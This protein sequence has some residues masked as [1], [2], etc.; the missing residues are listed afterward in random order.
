MKR[1]V[2][3]IVLMLCAF[4]AIGMYG[5][6]PV[7]P[8]IGTWEFAAPMPEAR[9]RATAVALGDYIYVIGGKGVS[10]TASRRVDRYDPDSDSWEE[11]EPLQIGRFDAASVVWNNS[12]VVVG[13]RSEN[14]QT[15]NTVE[16][17]N[18][19]TN[20]WTSLGS[21]IESREGHAAVVLNDVIYTAGGSDAV[22]RIFDTVEMYDPDL[23]SWSVS[24][25]WMLDFPRASFA[26]AAVNDS[27]FTIGGFNTFGPLSLVQ[28][29]HPEA[30]TAGRESISPARGGLAAVQKGDRVFALGGITTNFQA[31]STT[32]VYFPAENRWET[33]ASMNTPRAQF[34]AVIFEN[35]LF[36]FGG[37]DAQGI[38][39]ESVEVFISGVA[40][41]ATDDAFVTNE[42]VPLSFNV[43]ANDSDPSG[44]SITISNLSK[45]PGGTVVQP[46]NGAGTLT[47][48]PNKDFSG[49]DRFTYTIV[50]EEGSVASAE[51]VITVVP[52]NDPPAFV[53]TPIVDGVSG[54]VYAYNVQV[55][56][57][58]GPMV[59]ITTD[60]IPGWLSLTDN[61]DG[62]ALLTGTPTS[63]DVGNHVV[64]LRASDGTAEQVQSFIISVFQ[65]IPPIPTLVAPVN[66]ADSIE[67]PVMFTWSDLGATSWDIQISTNS[68][69]TNI[70][71]NVPNLTEAMHEEGQ[72]VLGT[73]YFWRVR[74]RNAVGTSDW[75]A[76]WGFTVASTVGVST[77]DEVPKRTLT[78]HPPFPNPTG[79]IVWIEVE[80][81]FVSEEHLRI[82]I[83]DIR[84]RLIVTLYDAV[85]SLGISQFSWDGTNEWGQLAASGTYYVR[86]SHGIEQ[87][88]KT[89]VVLR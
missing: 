64:T 44:T 29:F 1:A 85:P 66:N 74:A 35:E 37:E 59:T 67:I 65:G 48:T 11:V 71:I 57:V 33:E 81:E 72:L 16:Q 3:H 89:L 14:N 55:Q 38:I 6:H 41:I 34:P 54:E 69:F 28:R 8:A 63:G 25:Q 4:V 75:S 30:G 2:L 70:L 18:P 36:V 13:G 58:D 12:I 61:G 45:P 46:S 68:E 56:D 51:V 15:L 23:D 17:Y 7:P 87:H 82:E 10:G 27:A 80:T 76:P 42:D 84:G 88:I 9:S 31:V 49:T 79:G 50:N 21:L 20:T 86:L 32:S 62:T 83:Y 24:G 39:T 26:M 40:P 43:L 78:L 73:A 5:A 52:I 53:S 77:E 22:G 19:E 47:Y 60:A